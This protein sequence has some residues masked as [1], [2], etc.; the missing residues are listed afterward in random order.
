VRRFF[1]SPEV[2]EAIDFGR[3]YKGN[4]LYIESNRKA[5]AEKVWKAIGGPIPQW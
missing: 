1:G 2:R 5:E 4:H 3:Y